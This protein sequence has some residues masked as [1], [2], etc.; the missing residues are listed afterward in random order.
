[1]NMRCVRI[2]KWTTKPPP[3]KTSTIG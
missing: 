1:V 2:E 3:H